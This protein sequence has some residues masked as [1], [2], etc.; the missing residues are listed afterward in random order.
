MFQLRDPCAPALG[1]P[2][3]TVRFLLSANTVGSA[4]SSALTFTGPGLGPEKIVTIAS[5]LISFV[6]VTGDDEP[7][8]FKPTPQGLVT[9][10]N[11]SSC[12]TGK[13]C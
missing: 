12:Q 6:A 8:A 4:L 5:P 13:K 2:E 1:G 10:L 7:L 11:L 9:M 3:A